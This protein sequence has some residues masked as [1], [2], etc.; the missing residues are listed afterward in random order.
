[1]AHPT[2]K[3]AQN[4]PAFLRPETRPAVQVLPVTVM[5]GRSSPSSLKAGDAQPLSRVSPAGCSPSKDGRR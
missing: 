3:A 5:T 4:F 1:M 2:V